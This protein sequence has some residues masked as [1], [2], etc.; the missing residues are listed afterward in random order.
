MTDEPV[1]TQRRLVHAMTQPTRFELLQHA[2][3][4]E[5]DAG[6][7]SQREMTD[8]LEK[9][10]ATVSEHVE[11]LVEAGVMERYEV[12]KDERTR[13]DPWVWYWFTEDGLRA[14]HAIRRLADE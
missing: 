7:I 14:Y 2:D 11:K 10:Q 8:A 1:E 5:R 12:P 9:S 6:R 4:V 13:D 3:A